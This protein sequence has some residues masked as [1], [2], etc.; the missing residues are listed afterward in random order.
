MFAVPLRAKYAES[1][2]RLL[3]NQFQRALYL[4]ST[5]SSNDLKSEI[6]A[7]VDYPFATVSTALNNPVPGELLFMRQLVF[8]KGHCSVV[9]MNSC[10]EFA[11]GC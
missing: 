3:H 4:E 11:F 7:V 6:Y 10:R 9:S 2:G 5:E 8:E 1:G